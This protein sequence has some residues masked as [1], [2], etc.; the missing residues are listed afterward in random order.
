MCLSKNCL[1]FFQIPRLSCV[2]KLLEDSDARV[3]MEA[4][5][6]LAEIADYH[7]E[8][9]KELALKKIVKLLEDKEKRVRLISGLCLGRIS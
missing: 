3:R 4:S 5:Y 7:R 6:A 2:I 9:V 8:K 1:H